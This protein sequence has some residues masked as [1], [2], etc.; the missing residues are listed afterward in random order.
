MSLF[1]DLIPEFVHKIYHYSLHLIKTHTH[2]FMQALACHLSL[3]IR[4]NILRKPTAHKQKTKAHLTGPTFSSQFPTNQ[5]SPQTQI[6]KQNKSKAKQNKCTKGFKQQDQTN[7]TNDHQNQSA[8][9]ETS[10][11]PPSSPTAAVTGGRRPQHQPWRR[12][13]RRGWRHRRPPRRP[14]ERTG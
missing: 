6:R 13:G 10:A 3:C 11:P 4:L 5:T 9:P 7:K 8:S 1:K 14:R 2:T 12:R